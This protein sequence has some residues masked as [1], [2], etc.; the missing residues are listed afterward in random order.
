MITYTFTDDTI[1]DSVRSLP[2]FYGYYRLCK[3]RYD[4]CKKSPLMFFLSISPDSPFVL[5]FVDDN[6]GYSR[7]LQILRRYSL[8]EF[9]NACKYVH[10]LYMRCTRVKQRIDYICNNY[11]SAYFVTFTISDSFIGY[12]YKDLWKVVKET[13]SFTS[14]CY[15]FNPDYSPNNNRLH[16]HAVCTLDKFNDIENLPYSIGFYKVEVIRKGL[17]DNG[18]SSSTK[19]SRYLTKLAKHSTKNGT[20][21]STF[22]RLSK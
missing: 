17:Y 9:M 22:S 2:C 14:S 10:N 11:S 19:I 12:P 13:L 4:L 16:F 1:L 15:V 7:F 5:H 20:L 21:K 3:D 6:S 18:T 8:D